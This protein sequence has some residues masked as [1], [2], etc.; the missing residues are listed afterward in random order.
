MDGWEEDCKL[1]EAQH[2]SAY[3]IWNAI[4]AFR[5]VASFWA[6]WLFSFASIISVLLQNYDHLVWKLQQASQKARTPGLCSYICSQAEALYSKAFQVSEMILQSFLPTGK[7]RGVMLVTGPQQCSIIMFG[8]RWNS[9]NISFYWCH[10]N[11]LFLRP[12]VCNG[13]ILLVGSK[14]SCCVAK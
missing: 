14:Q 1:G 3:I 6:V 12:I 8:T 2:L 7:K 9:M 4:P 10:C 11:V 13:S 5:I